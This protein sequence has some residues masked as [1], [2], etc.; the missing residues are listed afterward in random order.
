MQKQPVSARSSSRW[1]L[2]LTLLM[3]LVALSACS[4]STPSPQGIEASLTAEGFQAQPGKL[5]KFDLVPW[6]CCPSP[7]VESCYGNNANAPYLAVYLPNSPGQSPNVVNS[8][9]NKVVPGM[10]PSFRLR[11]DEAVL[12][13]GTTPPQ[14]TY[15][16]Y[17]P[18]VM[19]R[20]LKDTGQRT[21]LFSSITDSF[22]NA[23]IKTAGTPNGVSGNPFAQRFAIIYAA[24]SAIAERV[25]KALLQT[26]Y[27]DAVIN[28]NALPSQILTMGLDLDADELTIVNRVALPDDAAAMDAYLASPDA[29]VYRITPQ[30][31]VQPALFP[32]SDLISRNTGSTESARVT[33]INLNT[34]VQQLRDA[35]IQ[36]QGASYDFTELSTG[37]W[38]YDGRD[39]LTRQI[40]CLGDSR[41]TTYLRSPAATTSE[42][43]TGPDYFTLGADEFIIIYGVN[44][45][46]AGSSTYSSFSVYNV[47]Q[48]LGVIGQTSQDYSTAN[49]SPSY[50]DLKEN[51]RYVYAWKLARNCNK[52]PYC[53]EIPTTDC[54]TRKQ[55][56]PPG[57]PVATN[58]M[59]A[60]RNYLNPLTGVGPALDEIIP[61]RIIRFKPK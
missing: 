9:Y 49:L 23:R 6:C 42:I 43:S 27:P 39:C 7:L 37:L 32:V 52:E 13:V 2:L 14:M 36:K 4:S 21:R 10:A 48:M 22:N 38:L 61:D 24:D 8:L 56:D 59:I 57:V 28:I 33:T 50:L 31:T 40:D 3:L 12:L 17:T 46:A 1:A 51:N 11:A 34:T 53:T 18:Y 20:T 60:F 47:D 15:Y 35:I 25:R 30:N 58:I 41:D 55:T 29:S 45:P 54:A 44:H 5:A 19:L 26:G 16:S